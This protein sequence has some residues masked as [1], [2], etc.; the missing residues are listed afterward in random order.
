MWSQRAHQNP[1]SGQLPDNFTGL[2]ELDDLVRQSGRVGDALGRIKDAVLAHQH[3]LAEEQARVLKREHYEEEL[4]G[5]ASEF[6][7]NGAFPVGDSKKRR[8]V[9]FSFFSSPFPFLL[10]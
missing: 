6:K 9:R 3:A 8:G 4:T 10:P 5:F 1:R 2:L 7:E